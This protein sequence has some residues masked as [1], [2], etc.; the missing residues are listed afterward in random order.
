MD[1]KKGTKKVKGK[2]LQDAMRQGRKFTR[3]Q[4]SSRLARKK[5]GFQTGGRIRRGIRTGGDPSYRK[6]QRTC[7]SPTVLRETVKSRVAGAPLKTQGTKKKRRNVPR[8]MGGKKWPV[9]RKVSEL[10]EKTGEK[11]GEKMTWYSRA[12]TAQTT[13]QYDKN[14]GM[15]KFTTETKKGTR[16]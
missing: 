4:T 13:F 16:G 7:L 15:P 8:R 9:Q 2:G 14:S 1:K 5:K 11:R 10:P 3:Q 6:S 12:L